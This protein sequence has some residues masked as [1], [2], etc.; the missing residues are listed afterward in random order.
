MLAF[1]ALAAA[2]ILPN[3]LAHYYG[4]NTPVPNV[5]PGARFVWAGLQINMNLCRAASL[6]GLGVLIVCRFRRIPGRLQPGHWVL[7]LQSIAM[8]FG[9]LLEKASYL[10]FGNMSDT[11]K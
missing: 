6:V 8:I 10:W 3:A 9:F 1:L 11:I 5:P 7:L 2:L 4:K